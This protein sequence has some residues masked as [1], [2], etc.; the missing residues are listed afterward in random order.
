MSFLDTYK[1]STLSQLRA[2]LEMCKIVIERCP[3]EYWELEIRGH[4]IAQVLYH[5]LF[6]T[7]FYIN[8]LDD[9]INN[10]A[11]NY[12]PP[13]LFKQVDRPTPSLS[14][15]V[16]NVLL[17]EILLEFI[18][19]ISKKVGNLI[20]NVS[21]ERLSEK[22]EFKWL[23]LKKAEVV[24]YLTRH[25]MEHIGQVSAY[26]RDRAPISMKWVGKGKVDL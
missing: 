16:E 25:L 23:S 19:F 22:S 5:G 2:S 12:S 13:E 11:E 21:E 26:I 3:D 9:Q 24:L 10:P 14:E 20:L 4:K 18:N 6:Y 7:D 15:P 8:D 1:E 17:K